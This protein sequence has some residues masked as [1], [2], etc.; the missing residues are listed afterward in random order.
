MRPTTMRESIGC[1]SIASVNDEFPSIVKYT[2]PVGPELKCHRS[3]VG[4]ERQ[5][6]DSGL[7]CVP[8]RSSQ[9]LGTVRLKY[10]IDALWGD[11]VTKFKVVTCDDKVTNANSR[12]GAAVRVNLFTVSLSRNH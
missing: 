6:R 8:P 4:D 7:L 12:K 10:F 9:C 5:A 11:R 1:I 2:C 3:K